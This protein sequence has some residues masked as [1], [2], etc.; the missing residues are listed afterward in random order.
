MIFKRETLDPPCPAYAKLWSLQ[1]NLAVNLT[2]D[3]LAENPVG[4]FGT[5]SHS[6]PRS[7]RYVRSDDDWPR[8]RCAGQAGS[9]VS[10]LKILAA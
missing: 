4:W 9:N 1:V 2:C 8:W 7:A 3:V 5:F 6:Y 10:R